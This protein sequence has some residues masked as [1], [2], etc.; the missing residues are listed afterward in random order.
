M[1]WDQREWILNQRRLEDERGLVAETGIHLGSLVR[2]FG[3]VCDRRKLRVNVE[4]TQVMLVGKE[5][6]AY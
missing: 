5:R 6:V 3:Q 1:D 2:E 4:E